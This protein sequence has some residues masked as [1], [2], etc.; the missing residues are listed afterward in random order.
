VLM[1]YCV[2]RNLIQLTRLYWHT[3][4]AMLRSYCYEMVHGIDTITAAATY[5][6]CR[7]SADTSTYRDGCLYEPISYSVL[8]SLKSHCGFSEQDVF[9][10]FGCGMGRTICYF[11]GI[12]MK[13]II[14]IELRNEY[15]NSARKNCQSKVPRIVTPVE[16]YTADAATFKISEGNVFY[17]F[18][19]FGLKTL[20][21][22]IENIRQ[23]LI[24]NPRPIR[25]LYCYPVFRFVFDECS[26]LQREP[27]LTLPWIIIWWNIP[28]AS[29]AVR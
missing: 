15:A 20:N 27:D 25:I 11:A 24:A 2:I 8:R 7:I 22:V 21:A 9:V 18:N 28:D 13:K 6:G 5:S 19:P 4:V 14:G 29:I 26:W 16:I 10:D 23:S 1:T 17:F 3:I 12:P